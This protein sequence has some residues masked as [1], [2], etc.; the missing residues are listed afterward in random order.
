MKVWMLWVQGDDAT[1]LEAA[2]DD[3]MT[4]Q[5]PPGWSEEVL[6]VR[7]LVFD[8]D[9][10]MRVLEVEVPGVYESFEI[11]KSKARTR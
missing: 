8:N 1:W 5:N 4:A 10:E 9:Y 6:R 11:P 2:W 7:K 3:E